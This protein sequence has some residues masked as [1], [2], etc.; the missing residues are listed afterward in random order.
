MYEWHRGVPALSMELPGAIWK[1]EM[2][3][4]R[5]STQE[6]GSRV[7]SMLKLADDSPDYFSALAKTRCIL[8]LSS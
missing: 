5:Y 7:A 4:L 8:T 3:L 6:Y 2:S 1:K